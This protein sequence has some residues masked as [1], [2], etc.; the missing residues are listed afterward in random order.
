MI[1]RQNFLRYRNNCRLSTSKHRR[2]S[3]VVAP[4]SFVIAN[5]MYG[6]EFAGLTHPSNLTQLES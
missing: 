1:R 6:N 4:K 2:P 3:D 5:N